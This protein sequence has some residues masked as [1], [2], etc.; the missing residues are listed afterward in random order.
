M[1]IQ[2]VG[3][4]TMVL[5]SDL[6]ERLEVFEN[7]RSIASLPGEFITK[8]VKG[9]L[10]H[11]YQAAL[12][13]GRMQFY[14]G[15]DGDKI[16]RLIAE[17]A[18]GKQPADSDQRLFQQLAAQIIAGGVPAVPAEVARVLGGM[19]NSAV[20]KA[21][22]VLI[23]SVA[24][25]IIATHLGVRLQESITTTQDVDIAGGA[26]V[27]IAVPNLRADIPAAIESLQMGFFPVPRLSNKEPST[28][29]AIRGKT[30]RIDLVTTT[31]GENSK[32]VFIPRFNAAAQPLKYL[33]Y[34]VEDPVDAAMVSGTPWLIKVPQ[35]AR[36]ALH[37]LIISQERDLASAAK[38]KKDILQAKSLLEI[39]REDMPAEIERAK[40]AIMKRPGS[41]I[42]KLQRVCKEHAI[43]L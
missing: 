36:F 4:E 6:R 41:W 20:F 9:C 31:K 24:L 34:L 26:R 15:R 39:L 13:G 14:L 33:D 3:G 37:K 10:Y 2:R 42:K 35:P 19:A 7:L 11:Y 27:S 43:K 12:P 32:P 22:G 18:D 25:Q 1:S 40:A 38:R 5:Y 16:R 28:S 23:G 30:L 21:G 17:R 8:K 29:Y